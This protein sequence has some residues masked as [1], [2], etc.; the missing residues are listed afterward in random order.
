MVYKLKYHGPQI[1]KVYASVGTARELKYYNPL[2]VFNKTVIS[3][4]L[5]GNRIVTANNP[6]FWFSTI[7]H[8]TNAN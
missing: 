2:S 8:P 4:A 1:E 6:S 5:V 3:F 7:S